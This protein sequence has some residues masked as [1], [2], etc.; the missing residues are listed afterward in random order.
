MKNGRL[1]R[2][3]PNPEVGI[4]N[5]SKKMDGLKNGHKDMHR[6]SGG[7]TEGRTNEYID[8]RRLSQLPRK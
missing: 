7:K 2:Q 5:H 1:V 3:Q 6:R 8:K 4:V